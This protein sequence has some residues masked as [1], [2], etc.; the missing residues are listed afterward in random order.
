[1]KIRTGFVSNSS[2]SSFIIAYNPKKFSKDY[3]NR[4]TDLIMAINRVYRQKNVDYMNENPESS[5]H[6]NV[7]VMMFQEMDNI[8]GYRSVQSVLDQLMIEDENSDDIGELNQKAIDYS[9]KGM[10]LLF[11]TIPARGDGG[12]ALSNTVYD[13]PE[14][15]EIET[16]DLIVKIGEKY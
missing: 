5:Y 1:L 15:F 14:K 7:G 13:N 16:K 10:H 8:H 11:G 2:S 4:S 3:V 12:S 6:A 9:K